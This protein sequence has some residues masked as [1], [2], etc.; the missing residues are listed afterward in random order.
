MNASLIPVH[1]ST[2]ALKIEGFIGTPEAARKTRGNQFFF[3]NDRF[4]KSPYLNHAI[5]KA[6]EQLIPE[7]TYPFYAI[8]LYIDSKNIDINVH[9]TKQEIK[10][11]DEASL[12]LSEGCC[13]TLTSSTQY[14]TEH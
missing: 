11:E 10:F 1:E 5:S 4:I 13:S 14:H 3:V 6:F 7:K 12:Q 9:P 2:D 8:Y